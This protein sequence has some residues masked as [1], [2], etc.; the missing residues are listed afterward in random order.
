MRMAIALLGVTA[1]LVSACGAEPETA[2]TNVAT[3]PSAESA[4]SAPAVPG[5]GTVPAQL[6][7]TATT[8]GGEQFSGQSLLGKPAVLW[9][10]AP[11]CPTC[12]RE[13]PLVGQVAADNPGVRFVGVA[14]L[15]EQ[16]A[17]QGFVDRFPIKD[18]TH[19]ADVD[20]AVWTRFGVT[21]QPAY[22]FIDGDGIVEVVRGTLSEPE[23]TE[24]VSALSAS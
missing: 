6:Q 9:F 10:W 1:G 14:G 17:M 4:A 19:L 3:S 12:Q 22:A 21:Q 16:P 20:G 13:A 2:S 23:L 7:F 18:F 8:L 5:E 15:D 11:W 24:R